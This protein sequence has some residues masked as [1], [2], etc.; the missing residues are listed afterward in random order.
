MKILKK[1]GIALLVLIF[2]LCLGVMVCAANPALSESL[3]AYLNGDETHPGILTHDENGKLVFNKG[4]KE[5][6]PSLWEQIKTAF[7]FGDDDESEDDG[8]SARGL[9]A[10][11]DPAVTGGQTIGQLPDGMT[12]RSG[13]QPVHGIT[14]SI[15]EDEAKKLAST[16]GAGET[17]SDLDFDAVTYPFYEM[18]TDVQKT[19]YKQIYANAEALNASFVP[20]VNVTPDQTEQTFE[21]VFGDHPELFYVATEY[22]VKYTKAN[23]VVEIDL[24]YYT[25]ANDLSSASVKFDDAAQRIISG[26]SAYS[27]DYE[28]EK[29]VHD[30][31][32]SQVEYNDSA[33]LGQSAYGALVDGSCVCAGYTRA[34]QYILQK[35]GIPCYYCT[36]TSGEDHAWNIVGLDDGFYNADLT[37]DD[38]NP[39]TYDYFN[40]S[41]DDFRGTHRRTGLSVNLPPC[42]GKKYSNLEKEAPPADP[43][44]DADAINQSRPESLEDYYDRTRDPFINQHPIEPLRYE[45]PTSG[46]VIDIISQ[47]VERD[48]DKLKEIGLKTGDVS[49]SLRQYYLDCLTGM[50]AAGTGE[51]TF[52][53]IVPESIYPTIE[54]EYGKGNYKA[55]YL[56]EAMK[57]LGVNN[58]NIMIQAER[59]GSGVYKLYHNVYTWNADKDG[60]E[61]AASN[62]TYKSSDGDY[63]AIYE[64]YSAKIK[65]A[66]EKLC[67][68]YTEEAKGNT[69]GTTGLADIYYNKLLS[70]ASPEVEG[71]LKMAGYRISINGSAEEF[72]EWVQKLTD[73]YE[74]EA[75]KLTD[76]YLGSLDGGN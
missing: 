9:V 57:R 22:T 31:V 26:A 66:S 19:L 68:E 11:L 41:D 16:V 48:V 62:N 34:C 14:E 4:E 52:V 71:V 18:L 7:G 47:P 49:W 17:G 70:L 32:I 24:S 58:C 8:N 23:Q 73:V 35:L 10:E 6:K 54:S 20:T 53:A 39:S 30:A 36:G 13:A 37:W 63:K 27:T 75:T 51:K 44:A 60:N 61:I 33:A 59:L 43:V 56:N 50:V 74:D 69:N 55:G 28:K 38:T 12:G 65:E 42:N 15:G 45:D 46:Q 3:G 21:A 72:D 25:I 2:A 67:G 64:A 40:K 5:D 76:L 29:Y 1:I